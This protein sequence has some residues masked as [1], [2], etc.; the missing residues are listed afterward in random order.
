MREI[1]LYIAQSMDGYI[2]RENGSVKWLDDY[3]DT[4]LDFAGFF[5]SIDVCVMGRRTY[6]QVVN[7]LSPNVWPYEGKEVIVL[8]SHKIMDENIVSVNVDE[9]LETISDIEGKV[10]I[11]GGSLLLRF[12]L[13]NNLVDK[14]I[15]TTIPMLLGKGVSLFTQLDNEQ[16]YTVTSVENFSGLIEVTYQR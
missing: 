11:V 12:F 1:I 13:E 14:M 16:K 15:I 9:L 5:D 7:E 4:E 3:H 6:E 10:W 8:S 2:A